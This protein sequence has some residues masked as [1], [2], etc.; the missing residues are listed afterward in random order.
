MEPRRIAVVGG[1]PA[2]LYFSYLWK[3]RHPRTEV[4]LFERN[5]RNATWGFGVVFSD[6]ALDFLRIDDAETAGVLAD[7][8]ERWRDLTINHRGQ[9]VAIDGVGFSAIG[10]LDLLQILQNRAESVGV[11]LHFDQPAPAMDSGH[12]LIVA[13]DGV[14]SSIRKH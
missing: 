5:P 12:D 13:A 10:R 8:M 2:G 9:S 11:Q 4:E 1:G 3:R 6:R 14:N 7:R